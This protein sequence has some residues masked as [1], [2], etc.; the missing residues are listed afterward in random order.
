M[1]A[2][3]HAIN[4]CACGWVIYT[5][6]CHPPSPRSRLSLLC[7]RSLYPFVFAPP[8]AHVSTIIARSAPLSCSPPC[9]SFIVVLLRSSS[10]ASLPSA[11]VAFVFIPSVLSIQCRS[12]G[13]RVLLGCHL[14]PWSGS[15]LRGMLS[16]ASPLPA[17]SVSVAVSS[18]TSNWSR[19][20]GPGCYTAAMADDSI[21][22]ASLGDQ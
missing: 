8:S 7:D 2:I 5:V 22:P 14:A 15:R 1:P 12:R 6:G 21:D 18:V 20:P 9:P 17:F 11:S 19:V 3:G 16:S 13:L 4:V 10:S